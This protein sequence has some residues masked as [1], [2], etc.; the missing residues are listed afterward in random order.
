[1][2]QAAA[3]ST[4][5]M[6]HVV[7]PAGVDDPA[8]P[9]GGNRYDRRICQGLATN[10]WLLA[11]HAIPGA[12]WPWPDAAAEAAL[13][14]VLAGIPDNALVLIDGLLSSGA[15][16]VLVPHARRLRLIVLVHMPFGDAPAGHRPPPGVDAAAGE[17]AVLTAARAVVT[18]SGWT[19]D[20]LLRMYPLRP[21]LVVVAAPGVDAAAPATGSPAGGRLLCVAAVSPHKGHDL[22]L[23]ALAELAE[24]AW[25][26]SWVGELDRDPAFVERLR[27]QA[28][29][30]GIA[31]RL[32]IT[33]PLTGP[34]LERAYAETDLLVLASR[35]ESYGMVVGEALARGL[36][37]LATTVGGLPEALGT[38]AGGRRPGL[39]VRPDDPAELTA[40]LRDWLTDPQLRRRLRQAAGER[41]GALPGW[42]MTTARIEGVLRRVNEPAGNPV[43]PAEVDRQQA[44][45][46]SGRAEPG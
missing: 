22:L 12:G 29:Q 16:S 43:S 11:E 32:L 40:A 27:R 1:V 7:L 41:R 14:R 19:R 17:Q 18:T 26:C 36:P 24:L 21:E 38:A 44:T 6:L 4:V 9:S 2:N 34:E 31:E 5:G 30:A 23:A 35:A 25:R 8:R 45:H 33:G 42:P 15:P 3:I 10:G 46:R 39:L 28:E 37:V 20:R 13:A